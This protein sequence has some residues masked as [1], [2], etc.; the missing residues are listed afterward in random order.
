MWA[1]RGSRTALVLSVSDNGI[2]IHPRDVDRVFEMFCRLNPKDAYA[3]TGM[4]L[5]IC[6][7]IVE[8]HGG[9]VWVEANPDAGSTFKFTI[10]DVPATD[11]SRDLPSNQGA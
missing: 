10:P 9:R 3:G 6:K 1:P 2:G 7:R 5:S 8:R 4:G 11:E